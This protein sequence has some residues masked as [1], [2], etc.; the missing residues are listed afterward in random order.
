[1]DVK[2]GSTLGCT[3]CKTLLQHYQHS[4]ATAYRVGGL[5]NTF[6][7]IIFSATPPLALAGFQAL[8]SS[9]IV[10]LLDTR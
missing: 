10:E 9:A 2:T 8:C 5:I 3:D 6:V 4:A 7:K 1:M